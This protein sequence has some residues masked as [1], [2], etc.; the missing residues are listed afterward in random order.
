MH[1]SAHRALMLAPQWGKVLNTQS[2]LPQHTCRHLISSLLACLMVLPGF[3]AL[4]CLE[5]GRKGHPRDTPLNRSYSQPHVSDCCI[6]TQ[7]SALLLT[8]R[9]EL[10]V[11]C[12]TSGTPSFCRPSI[13][14]STCALAKPCVKR[15]SNTTQPL[16]QHTQSVAGSAANRYSFSASIVFK[17]SKLSP[18]AVQYFKRA[19]VPDSKQ[20]TTLPVKHHRR[21]YYDLL[22]SQDRQQQK[23]FTNSSPWAIG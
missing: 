14:H 18:S 5:H 21:R 1:K 9:C 2:F 23:L 11:A 16:S 22:S 13:L 7:S 6:C 19:T 8:A 17:G 15:Q 4:N 10:L 20:A 3:D 12:F